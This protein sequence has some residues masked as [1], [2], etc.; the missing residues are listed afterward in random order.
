MRFISLVCD[1]LR[2]QRV[3]LKSQV[4]DMTAGSTLGE[5]AGEVG[6]TNFL[7]YGQLE[8]DGK[9]VAL[10]QGGRP[11]DSVAAGEL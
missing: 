9:I 2:K 1:P 10:L 5:L 4:V 3:A 7:G 11:V 6:R 8:A